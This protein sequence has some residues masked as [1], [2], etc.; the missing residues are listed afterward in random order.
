MELRHHPAFPQKRRNIGRGGDDFA[1][2]VAEQYRLNIIPSAGQGIHAEAFPQPG[3]KLAGIVPFV[4]IHQNDLGTTGDIPASEATLQLLVHQR[5]AQGVPAGL[6]CFHES[7]VISQ[8]RADQ[9]IIVPERFHC[10]QRLAGQNLMDAAD[11]VAYFPADF[12][13]AHAFVVH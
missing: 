7:R 10:L 12:K 2:G 6:V 13:Q 1:A 9:I 5:V 11:L 3:Q 4:E 8:I